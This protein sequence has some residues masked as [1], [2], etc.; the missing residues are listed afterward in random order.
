MQHEDE[1]LAAGRNPTL[2]VLWLDEKEEE[3]GHVAPL[4][5]GGERISLLKSNVY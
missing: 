5:K 2:M 3:K 1:D 4:E